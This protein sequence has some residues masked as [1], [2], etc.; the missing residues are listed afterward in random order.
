MRTALYILN[1]PCQVPRVH[2]LP[3][4]LNDLL[5]CPDIRD[6]LQEWENTAQCLS[7]CFHVLGL[8]FPLDSKPPSGGSS[9]QH[10]PL[11]TCTAEV[12]RPEWVLQKGASLSGVTGKFTPYEGF[13]QGPADTVCIWVCNHYFAMHS[14]EKWNIWDFPN[15]SVNIRWLLTESK[16]QVQRC[17]I[18]KV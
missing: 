7:T 12:L 11:C 4:R 2:S 10:L 14:S 17:K 9:A 5:K 16:L 3:Q 18:G 6:Y 8:S 13:N 15:P 1:L